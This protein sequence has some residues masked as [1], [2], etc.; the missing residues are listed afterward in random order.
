MA[1]SEYMGRAAS[2]D[3]AAFLEKRPLRFAMRLSAYMLP[4]YPWG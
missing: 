3:I 2:E 4:F 1:L